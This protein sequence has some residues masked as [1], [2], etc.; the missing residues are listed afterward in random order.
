MARRAG[1]GVG[2]KYG[3]VAEQSRVEQ[4]SSSVC[5]PGRVT[6][7]LIVSQCEQ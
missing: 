5:G 3:V 2:D 7:L 1:G 4:H 6:L